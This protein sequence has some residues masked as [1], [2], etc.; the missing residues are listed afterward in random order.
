VTARRDALG[1]VAKVVPENGRW[2]VYLG[3]DFWDAAAADG[4][5]VETV[6]H[7]ITDYATQA[8]ATVAAEWYR[9]GADRARPRR[10]TE[11]F[12]GADT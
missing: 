6:W 2:A 9:R 8:A 11:G 1:V 5:P 12:G 3:V 7:R 10:E 4:N